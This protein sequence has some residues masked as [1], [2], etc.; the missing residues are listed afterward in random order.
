VNFGVWGGSAARAVAGGTAARAV[1]GGTAARAVAGGTA[2]RA[3]AGLAREATWCL[4]GSREMRDVACTARLDYVLR[5]S[6]RHPGDGRTP[7]RRRSRRGAARCRAGLCLGRRAEGAG[8]GDRIKGGL[9]TQ[10][11][12]LHRRWP[13]RPGARA[14]ARS[15]CEGRAP[16]CRNP[17]E[18]GGWGWAP[19]CYRG[20]AMATIYVCS[21][22]AAEAA[23]WARASTDEHATTQ[24]AIS[25]PRVDSRERRVVVA[26]PWE[27][28]A[29]WR[30]AALTAARRRVERA[31]PAGD[32]EFRHF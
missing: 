29:L 30:V 16:P 14:A 32:A 26:R 8:A 13:E 10:S 7:S 27:A 4:E 6:G 28:R 19:A 23:P 18:N 24:C 21:P 11:A 3:V 25:C 2:A 17:A 9:K 5:G 22:W 1:A 20:C 31:A 15:R 12:C